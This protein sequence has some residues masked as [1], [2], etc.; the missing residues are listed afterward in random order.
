MN[1]TPAFNGLFGQ[2]A[3]KGFVLQLLFNVEG[4]QDCTS[5]IKKAKDGN[6]FE[7]EKLEIIREKINHL[8]KTKG[9]KK[10]LGK[11]LFRKEL[12]S[13]CGLE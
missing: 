8:K 13:F 9:Q 4:G 5:D 10:E 12:F 7:K 6:V 1:A 11:R 2:M 3:Q